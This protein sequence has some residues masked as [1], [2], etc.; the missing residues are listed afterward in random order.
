MNRYAVATA[1]LGVFF[2]G[3]ALTM[4]GAAVPEV[5]LTV[6]DVTVSP[7]TPTAGEPVTVEATVQNSAGSTQAVEIDRVAIVEDGETLVDAGGVGSLAVGD[8]TTVPLTTTFDE[9]GV[10]EVTVEFTGTDEDGQTVTVSQ[11]LTLVVEGGAPSIETRNNTA[12]AGAPANITMTVGNPTEATLRNV[13]VSLDGSGLVGEIDRRVVPSIDPGEETPLNFRLQ[14]E[15]AGETLLETNMSYTTAAGTEATVTSSEVLQIQPREERVAVRVTTREPA[16][17]SGGT[18]L[19]VGVAGILDQQNNNE[20]SEES[21]SG[22]R[23]TVSNVGNAPVTDVV[24]DPRAG[25]RSLGPRPVTDELAAGTEESVVV[26]LERTPAAE[27]RF[28]AQYNTGGGESTASTTYRPTPNQG[29]VAV[30]GVDLERDGEELVITGD[31]GNRGEGEVTGVVVAVDE[32]E[33]VSPSYPARDFFVGSIDGDGFAPF[34]LTATID[35]NATQVPLE[36]DY[37]VAGDERTETVRFPVEGATETGGNGGPSA[38]VIGFVLVVL[39]A[40]LTVG[41]LWYRRG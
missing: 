5:R 29:A 21:E 27:V 18:D 7:E 15:S 2:F 39:L 22:V 26:S 31:I 30:T 17:E 36:V 9:A 14:P 41:G 34:E 8:G 38:L 1:V 28:E 40:I 25:N 32:A 37:L 12:V 35:E 3:I 23:V 20:E 4:T 24:L 10:H 13:V 6:D 19:G 16:Q 33:G 11:P